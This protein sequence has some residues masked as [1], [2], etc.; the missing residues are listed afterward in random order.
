MPL[1]T[2]DQCCSYLIQVSISLA[3]RQGSGHRLLLLKRS[4]KQ[5]CSLSRARLM[6]L[7]TTK[8]QCCIQD[9]PEILQLG[10]VESQVH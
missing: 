10:G 8:L 5:C 6:V 7:G 9:E 4:T 2:S 3:E 1:K